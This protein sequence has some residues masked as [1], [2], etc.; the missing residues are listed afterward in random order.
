MIHAHIT[1]WVLALILF[2]ISLG[3]SKSGKRK[4]QKI[5][6]M[7]LRLV[8]ILIIITGGLLL[9]NI[10]NITG[11][12]I[13][14]AIVGL[15]V[16]IMLELIAVKTVK[17]KKTTGHWILLIITLVLVFYLGFSL[18]LGTDLF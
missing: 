15:W 11:L 17:Q 4:G 8:Y 9:F 13:L 7:I 3:L 10:S 16:I 5:V 1:T 12:Y 18:P 2:F 14:K 6:Q